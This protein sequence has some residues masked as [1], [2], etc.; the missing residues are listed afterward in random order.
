MLK[1]VL[2][3]MLALCT[4]VL[5][6]SADTAYTGYNYDAWGESVPA[7]NSYLPVQT[8][9]LHES[10][11]TLKS[12]S[13]L[14]VWQNQLIY[15]SDSGNN[16]IVVLDADYQFVREIVAYQSEDG[17][18]ALQNPSGIFVDAQAQLY[19][20][21]PDEEKVVV[22]DEN[23]RLVCV[24]GRPDS[25][26]LEDTTVY[27]PVRV[28]ANQLGTVFVL[29]QGLY[30]G[31]VMYDKQGEFLGF[32]GANDVVVTLDVLMDYMWKQI[33]TQ[34]Q[35]NSMARY[36]PVQYV[37]F[38]IDANNFIYTCTNESST[39]YNEISKLNSLGDNVLISYTR[40]VVSQTNNYGDLEQ[41]VYLGQT[42]DTRFVDLAIHDNELLYALDRT[43][44]RVFVYDQ[45]SHLLS[46]FG[47]S[48]DQLGTFDTPVAVDTL[49]D[50]VMV[51]DQEK[52]TMTVFE[53]TYYG[54]LVENAVLLYIDGLYQEARELWEEVILYNVNC[55]LAYTGI[56]K[57]LYEEG[58]YHEAMHYF[59]LGYDREGYSRAFDE[60]RMEVARQFF[61]AV[62]TGLVVLV[63][64]IK[65]WTQVRRRKSKKAG[66][67]PV[68]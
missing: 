24:Y 12:P 31:A 56:G 6:A 38:D 20:C 40:N 8:I 37:A 3:L 45:E 5:S 25:D 53:R 14:F 61:P 60:Y 59:K 19:I 11:T 54:E 29:P 1:K 13:D 28:I 67:R 23:N 64:G 21:L 18:V 26:L 27:K 49:G 30:L 46:V 15:I 68:A 66:R 50:Q 10:G 44:G 22:L 2:I 7:P 17:E 55:E 35:V 65:V 47:G 41:E 42:Q 52:G 4:L 34:D 62:C 9:N 16:R 63:V 58:Q 48:G 57:A 51:L 43:R 36:V 33:L 32:Y 39:T